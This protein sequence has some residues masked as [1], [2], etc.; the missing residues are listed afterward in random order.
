MSKR[1]TYL[2]FYNNIRINDT[3]YRILLKWGENHGSNTC[4]SNDKGFQAVIDFF[5][6]DAE[7]KKV[8]VVRAGNI[9]TA[10]T[11]FTIPEED[12]RREILKNRMFTLD[13]AAECA[14]I[15]ERNKVQKEIRE[16]LQGT[17]YTER[18]AEIKDFID[19]RKNCEK[20]ELYLERW[21]ES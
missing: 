16:L 12:Q 20:K 14:R 3:Q 4:I 21:R 17:A 7:T 2:L 18:T 9:E 1:L 13:L 6:M 15:E 11:F 10:L 8:Q 19:E 5:Q